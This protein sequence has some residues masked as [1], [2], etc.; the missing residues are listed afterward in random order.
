M[1]DCRIAVAQ[2]D[3]LVG[4]MAANAQRIIEVTQSILAE[5]DNIDLVVFPELSL[6]GY[7][8]EDLLFR[9][10]FY[11]RCQEALDTILDAKLA[12]TIIIGLPIKENDDCYNSAA[13]IKNGELI[14][15]Y[16]KRDL[17][18]YEV[19]D[20][21]RYFKS[22]K[23][24]CIITIN[25]I[26]ISVNICEDMWH[27]T[28]VQQAVKEGA[29]LVVSINASP[30]D[31]NKARNRELTLRQRT[32]ES[33]VPM[34]YCNIV[35]GQDEVVFDGG[36]MVL[37]AAGERVQQAA[38]F[39]EDI[40][41]VDVMKNGDSVD[42]KKHALLPRPSADETLY[43][44]LVLGVRDYVRKNNFPG[45][46]IGLSGG[47]DSALTLCV[48]VDALG[49]DN[50][51]V[52]LMPSRYSSQESMD[53]AI[54]QAETMK[55]QYDIISI[56]PMFEQFLNSLEPVFTGTQPDTT[57]ENIQARIRGSLLMALSNKFGSI[58]LTTGNKSEMSVGYSTLYGDLAGGFSVLKD[59]FKHMVYQ[60]SHYRNTLSPVIPE[61]VIT[62]APSAELADDQKDQ[63]TLPPYDVLDKIIELYVEQDMD[64]LKIYSDE[65][66]K[67]TVDRVIKM[68]NRN[69]YKRR[70][71]PIGVRT[72][73]RAFGK[74]RRYPITSGY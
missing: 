11:R 57:E 50:V 70:Q 14:T 62:R 6:T 27:V 71:A 66:N 29:K 25:D 28:P 30:F 15:T 59:I 9:S 17:P 69:E 1:S 10:G 34:I 58:V 56:E 40:M 5:H 23:A 18:N 74:D 64:P 38:Y 49:A 47:I 3:F 31:R 12:T 63:D 41:I 51:R 37:N 7:S 55:V 33:H 67:E 54:Q 39:E 19:F 45:A 35:G 60:L 44:T 65:L 8:P 36:S 22:G 2:I 43:Q 52:V 42:I 32:I 61:A 68:I 53:L 24:P 21:V 16:R 73:I 4:A 48:A 26:P 20:E 72:T 13:I 46:I